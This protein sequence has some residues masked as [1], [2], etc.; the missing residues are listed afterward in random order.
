MAKATGASPKQNELYYGD[1]LDVLRRKIASESVDLCYIDPPFN[2]KRNYFQIYNNQGGEDRAQAQAFVDTWEWG[3]EAND[4]IAWIT[5]IAQL[6]SGRLTEQTV[7][8]LRG[9][10]KVLKRGSLLAYL[11]HMTLRIVEIRRV[12]KPTGTFYL[13]CD[14][15]AS[16]YLKLI[17]DAVFCG[18]GGDF[19]NEIIWSYESGGRAKSDFARKH[20]V[21][22]RY[23]K[24]KDFVF[25]A[26]AVSS[27]RGET[28]HNHMKK[29][30][31][32]DGRAFRSIKSNGK[33][34]KYYDD[35]G[36]IPAD[37]WPISHL[38]QKDPER[39]GYPTQ[40]PEI[41][42]E[43]IIKASSNEGD[44]V[45]DAYCGCGTTVAVAQRLG[46]RWIGIDI[47]YQSISLILKRLQDKY[48]A[49]WPAIEAGILLDGVPRDIA[50]AVA[51]ANRKDDKTRKEFEK[52]SVL[53]YSNNQ[54]RINEKKGADAGIDGTAFFLIDASTNGKAIFQV[55]SGG[56][57]RNTLATLNSDRQREKAEFGFLI[58]MDAPTK[59][60]RD[61]IVAAGKYKHPLLHREDD[62]LQVIT[63]AEILRGDR[64]NLPMAR[65]D[66]VRSAK[67]ETGSDRQDSLL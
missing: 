4:G 8:L 15:T 39:L 26:A 46:R 31:D 47:T 36:V 55:K 44:V 66:A 21:I 24:S 49:E 23:S 62:R 1:N 6:Q 34:Y 65:L 22:F 11:I 17:L 16:H 37:V 58:S 61:E 20:D 43:R 54:A 57:T 5:D 33:I 25:N 29:H 9:L 14:P 67:A 63:V 38:Q 13:H 50:S 18:Q 12:L 30:I 7:E 19:R 60:M 53:T 32:E 48:P 41:I 59:A 64:L 56:A 2:S 40:K 28:R 42:L 45:L 27:P 35:E 3:D 10:E 51:L 52:W